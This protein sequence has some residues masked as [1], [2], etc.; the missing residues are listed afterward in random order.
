MALFAPVIYPNSF[1]RS[2][3]WP[4]RIIQPS[5]DRVQPATKSGARIENSETDVYLPGA[6]KLDLGPA[7]ELTHLACCE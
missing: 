3:C 5:A 4:R 1:A 6:R 7:R 2:D